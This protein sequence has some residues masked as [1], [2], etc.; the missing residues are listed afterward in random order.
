M[1]LRLFFC[2][3]CL[4][5]RVC[6]LVGTGGGF[7]AA[8]DALD[9]FDDLICRTADAECRDTLGITGAA[10]GETDVF[11]DAVFEGKI[12]L[13]GAD[14][15]GGKGIRCH[16]NQPFCICHD[17]CF[18]FLFYNENAVWSSLRFFW[19]KMVFLRGM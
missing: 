18:A 16:F 4:F 11:D 9:D 5:Q 17:K 12:N 19:V 3:D 10:A 14:A 8:A 2:F 6:Q 7:Y 1:A 15:A 13:A